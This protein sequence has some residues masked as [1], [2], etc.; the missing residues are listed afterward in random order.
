MI[1]GII[2]L[3]IFWFPLVNII[4]IGCGIA[5]IILSVMGSNAGRKNGMITGGLVMSIIGLALSF[6]VL[7]AFLSSL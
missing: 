1:L 7:V 6:I 4:S 3:I 2:S 5:G